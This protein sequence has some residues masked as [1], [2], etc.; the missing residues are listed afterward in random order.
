MGVLCRD[1]RFPVAELTDFLPVAGATP[2][3]IPSFRGREFFFFVATTTFF[4]A[5]ALAGF[6]SA[7]VAGFVRRV[8]GFFFVSG[9]TSGTSISMPNMRGSMRRW[10]RATTL[11]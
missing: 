4:F 1:A 5:D 9:N 8:A 11:R 10:C 6:F 2:S 3:C 7:A